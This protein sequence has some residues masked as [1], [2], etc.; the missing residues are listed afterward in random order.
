MPKAFKT[1]KSFARIAAKQHFKAKLGDKFVFDGFEYEVVGCFNRKKNPYIGKPVNPEDSYMRR[2][3]E[4]SFP[5]FTVEHHLV[6]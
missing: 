5:L 2:D 1:E 3:R 4:Y 6:S